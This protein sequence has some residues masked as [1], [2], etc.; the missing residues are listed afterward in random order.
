MTSFSERCLPICNYFGFDQKRS[1]VSHADRLKAGLD[2]LSSVDGFLDFALDKATV[3]VKLR[4]LLTNVYDNSPKD[5][6]IF[7]LPTVMITDGVSTQFRSIT[8]AFE[9]IRD[10]SKPDVFNVEYIYGDIQGVIM[11]KEYLYSVEGVDMSTQL[12]FRFF[13][14]DVS[15][16]LK[17]LKIANLKALKSLSK[18]SHDVL[19]VGLDILPERNSFKDFAPGQR[20]EYRGL[21]FKVSQ[22]TDDF[23]FPTRLAETYGSPTS[24]DPTVTYFDSNDKD[25]LSFKDFHFSHSCWVRIIWVPGDSD[26]FSFTRY[27]D[28]NI[29]C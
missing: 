6:R 18:R 23:T 14:K 8:K 19:G 28:G 22:E 29:D 3:V 2:Y 17:M 24:F 9:V 7:A 4:S 26:N 27:L 10:L 11:Q 20:F 1:F 21:N 13:Y 15:E 25:L 5:V 16:P 12:L